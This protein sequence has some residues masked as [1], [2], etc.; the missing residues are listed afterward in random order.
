MTHA[1]EMAIIRQRDGAHVSLSVKNFL[2]E[3]PK[4]AYQMPSYV[5]ST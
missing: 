1:F 2:K 4:Q 3:A 5:G